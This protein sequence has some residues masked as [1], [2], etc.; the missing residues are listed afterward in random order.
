MAGSIG[1]VWQLL[2]AGHNELHPHLLG[3]GPLPGVERG[4]AEI[5]QVPVEFPLGMG[6]NGV[7]V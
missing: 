5:G 7:A 1:R 6:D 3:G 4:E 2:V